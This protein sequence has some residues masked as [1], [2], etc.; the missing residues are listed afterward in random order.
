MHHEY[1]LQYAMPLNLDLAVKAMCSPVL[2]CFAFTKSS[3]IE[4][5]YKSGMGINILALTLR[6]LHLQM[7]AYIV[8]LIPQQ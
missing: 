6:E 4:L 7:D 2:T 1:N 8:S 5:H 3:H